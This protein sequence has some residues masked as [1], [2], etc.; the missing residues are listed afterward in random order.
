MDFA[1]NFSAKPA[2]EFLKHTDINDYSMKLIDARQSSHGSIYSL[3]PVELEILKTYIENN[4]GNS[5]IRPSKSAP[6]A[7]IVFNLKLNSSFKL[8][9]D[10]K[11][12][13]NLTIKNR[14]SFLFIEKSLDWIG[15][16]RRFT[17]LDF[18]YASH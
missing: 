2:T 13:N 1:E 12:L 3:G 10:Y 6:G 8:Y 9:I 11:R 17:Q 18:I 16:A 15:W 5:F 4:L 14:Y 7:P